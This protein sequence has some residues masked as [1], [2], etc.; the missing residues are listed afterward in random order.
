[1]RVAVTGGTG[2]VGAYTARARMQAGHEVRLLNRGPELL[3]DVLLPL[4]LQSGDVAVV[5]GDVTDPA[6]ME[7]LL[8]GV[9]AVVHTAAMVA[10]DRRQVEQMRHT[11]VEG[12]A[13]VLGRAAA[14]GKEATP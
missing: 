10:V 1:M 3:V 4:G 9:A 5:Q 11:N 6:T 8:D 12:S 7:R 13:L 2:F 14:L